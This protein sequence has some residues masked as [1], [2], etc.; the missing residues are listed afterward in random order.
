MSWLKGLFGRKNADKT[1]TT[2]ENPVPKKEITLRQGSPEFDEF[3][4]RGTLDSSLARIPSR[5]PF[6]S[7]ISPTRL[8]QYYD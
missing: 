8:R 7:F 4:A 1:Q 2:P 5:A 3:I 6:L